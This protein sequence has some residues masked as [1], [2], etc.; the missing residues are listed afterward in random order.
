[1][2]SIMGHSGKEKPFQIKLIL[3]AHETVGKTLN[4]F[5][6]KYFP[7]FFQGLHLELLSHVC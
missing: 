5:F 1:M 3:G 6:I 7:S 4:H 2:L